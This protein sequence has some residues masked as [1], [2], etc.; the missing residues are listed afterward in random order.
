MKTMKPLMTACSIILVA[1]SPAAL[2]QA[3]F[4]KITTG[5]VVTDAVDGQGCAWVDFDGDGDLDLYVSGNR[6]GASLLYR[7][8]GNG[9]FTGITDD[10]IVNAGVG[11]YS[12]SWADFDNDGRIDL[13]VSR[14]DNGPGL[15]FHQEADGT[16]TQTALPS[17]GYSSGSAWG[18]YNNDGFVDLL[19]GDSTQSVLWQNHGQ[20]N[21]VAVTDT[22]IETAGFGGQITWVDYDNDGDLDVFVT[23][24]ASP[25]AGRLYRNDGQGLFT[26]ITTGQLPQRSSY[27]TGASWGDYDNDGFPDVFVCRLDGD[28]QQ[29]LPSFLFHN[30]GDGTFTQIEQSPF[31][32]DTGYSPTCSWGDYDN[33]GWLDLIVAN[34]DNGGKNRLYHNN[35]DGSFSR[36]LTG[37]IADDLGSS[38]GV[39]WGDYDRDGF[40]DLFISNGTLGSGAHNDFLYHNDGNSNAWLTIKCVGTL[41][42]RSAIGAKVRVKATINGK[43][44]WQLREINT[45]SGLSQSALEAHF[46]L[47]NATNVETLRIEWPSGTVQEF[48]NVAA[49]QY[50]A[51]TEPPRLLFSTINGVP[52]FTLQGGRGFQYDVLASTNLMTWSPLGT[53]TI[54]NLN[55][56]APIIDTNAAASDRRFYRAVL[57]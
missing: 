9:V 23:S 45:G 44:F 5:P 56:T 17:G 15:L 37:S 11:T 51:I 40:L 53:L 31:T 38:A 41:S 27:C 50:L 21:L 22:P 49:R 6:T 32:D 28:F 54:T 42:N 3:S 14:Q 26:P 52:R 10:A 36:V 4:T 39:I 35:G 1:V 34:F 43:S 33:D 30:N 13:F 25:G 16:F 48:Q 2:A 19:V 46:G 7:N 20:G 47:G 24:G 12:A 57:H 18:D 55:S 8:D 29:S